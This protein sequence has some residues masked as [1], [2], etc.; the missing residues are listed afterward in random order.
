M[1]KQHSREKIKSVCENKLNIK[2]RKGKEFNGWFCINGKKTHRITVQKKKKSKEIAT[3]T[4]S[5]MANQLKLNTD[6]FNELIGCNI[7]L[8]GYK[9]ILKTKPD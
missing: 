3:K 1:S 4:Y 8:E 7:T 9:D 6:E 2:F 5:S